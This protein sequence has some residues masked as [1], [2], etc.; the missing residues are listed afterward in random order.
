MEDCSNKSACACAG[1]RILILLKTFEIESLYSLQLTAISF[2]CSLH[3][4]AISETC[5]DY[6]I[7]EIRKHIIHRKSSTGTA[8][9]E[10]YTEIFVCTK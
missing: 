5:I 10:E 3:K 8:R 4:A 9:F 7:L 1:H 2:C 6:K